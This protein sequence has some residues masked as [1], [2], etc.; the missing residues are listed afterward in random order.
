MAKLFNIYVNDFKSNDVLGF[1]YDL[2]TPSLSNVITS[3]YVLNGTL[4]IL[5]NKY[6]FNVLWKSLSNCFQS[7]KGKNDRTNHVT[8]IGEGVLK[9]VPYSIGVYYKG[10]FK[11]F[12][13]TDYSEAGL[14]FKAL[15]TL[16]KGNSNKKEK[17]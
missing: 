5:F 8:K 14:M 4:S 1:E 12:Y 15:F 7:D 6:S 13:I 17:I 11:S 10:V 3:R 2:Y 9:A 16:C